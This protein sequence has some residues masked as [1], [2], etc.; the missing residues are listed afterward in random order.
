MFHRLHLANVFLIITTITLTNQQAIQISDLQNNPGLLI[1]QQSKCFVKNGYHKIYHEID[2]DSYKPTLDHLHNIIVNLRIFPGFKDTVDLLQNRYRTI[3]NSYSNLLPK[4]RTK[5]GLFDFLGSGIKMITGNLDNYDLIQINN[6]I[7]QLRSHTNKIIRQDNIQ[8]EINTKLQD[9]INKIIKSLNEQQD[10]IR[11]QII[12]ARNEFYKNANQNI[13]VLNQ[14]FKI[15]HHLENF[16]TH[17][18]S[19][20]ETIQLAKLNV[21]SKSFLDESELKFVMERLEEQNV[22]LLSVDHAYQFLGIEAVYKDSKLYF[23]I[24]I[25]LLEPKQYHKL[26]LEPLPVNEKI[27]KLPSTSAIVSN[28]GTFFIVKPCTNIQQNVICDIKDLL[29]VSTDECYSKILNG[30]SGKCTLTGT[31]TETIIKR[32][33]DNNVI[34]VNAKSVHLE[35]DCNLSTRNLTGTFLIAFT[36]CSMTLNNISFSSRELYFRSPS[37]IIPLEGLIIQESNYEVNM[38]LEK[39]HELHLESRQKL[40]YVE[41]T[42]QTYISIGFSF[43]SIVLGFTVIVYCLRIWNGKK[44]TL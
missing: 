38:T 21:I 11:K 10:V 9:K 44:T 28:N 23:I 2:L 16:E 25:P 20:F 32:L 26:L 33:T 13:S 24:F 7:K 37:Q 14:V 29:D 4:T 3:L 43:I 1:L 30:E 27:I 5:R 15:S 6:D 19:I 40:N 41:T 39:L 12:T 34:L 8:I 31:S 17:L 35:T 18:D 36:N 22:T 42:N